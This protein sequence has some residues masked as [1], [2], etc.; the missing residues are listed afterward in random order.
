MRILLWHGRMAEEIVSFFQV[1]EGCF[2]L[3]V[4]VV[5]MGEDLVVCLF[6]GE[7]SQRIL[8]LYPES[9]THRVH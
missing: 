4:L 6:G 3:T 8:A 9:K 7:T 1:S 2:E 5:Q